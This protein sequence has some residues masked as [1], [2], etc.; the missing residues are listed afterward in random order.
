RRR[1]GRRSIA[2][3][4]T[5]RRWPRSPAP[6]SAGPRPRSGRVPSEIHGGEVDDG[7][8]AAGVEV[9]HLPF[10]SGEDGRPVEEMR[11]VLVHAGGA[12]DDVLVHQ[13]G[14]EAGGGDGAEGGGYG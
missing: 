13:G 3:A 7:A 14:P 9:G 11:P 6:A 1:R 10:R 5:T 4:S 12:R 2:E 8:N